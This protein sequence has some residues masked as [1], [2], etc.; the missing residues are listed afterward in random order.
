MNRIIN[1]QLELKVIAVRDGAANCRTLGTGEKIILR[2]SSYQLFK[3]VPGE[4]ADIDV[5]RQM[6]IWR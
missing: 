5:K 4:I 1:N 6:G 3:I 2:M